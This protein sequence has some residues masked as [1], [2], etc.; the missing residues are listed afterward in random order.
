MIQSGTRGVSRKNRDQL[1]DGDIADAFCR[2]AR[3][4]QTKGLLSDQHFTV[5]G[6]L[7]KAWAS[8]KSFK[9]KFRRRP[10]PDDPKNPTVDFHGHRRRNDTPES[11][12]DPNAPLY[13]KAV[14]REAKLGYLAHV[15][16]ENR[17]GFI[18]DTA[19]TGASGTAERDAAL[20]MLGERAGRHG[21][22]AWAGDRVE[23]RIR[24]M[25][26][27]Y[28]AVSGTTRSCFPGWFG[29]RRD[30]ASSGGSTPRCPSA[31]GASRAHA[32]DCRDPGPRRW[33]ERRR[34]QRR[35][36][37]ARAPAAVPEADRLVRIGSAGARFSN[38]ECWYPFSA[39]AAA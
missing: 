24:R 17:H 30:R 16:T 27:P 12:T 31:R 19:V 37:A 1:L 20:A 28:D 21:G 5:D 10:P 39:D 23:V 32:G 26:A 22:M 7:L 18:V 8:H 29:T 11:T 3:R 38:I 25:D 9:P 2:S 13:Q 35:R 34:I 36:C 14:G 6:T 4:L 33:R 15:L